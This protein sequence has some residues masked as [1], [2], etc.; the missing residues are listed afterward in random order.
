[1]GVRPRR[2]VFHV[3]VH[4]LL[5]IHLGRN[6]LHQARYRRGDVSHQLVLSITLYGDYAGGRDYY[7]GHLGFG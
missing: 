6:V 3:W 1:M 7:L 5:D 2:G 4:C